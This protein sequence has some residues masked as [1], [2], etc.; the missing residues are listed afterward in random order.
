MLQKS[1]P[2]STPKHLRETFKPEDEVFYRIDDPNSKIDLEQQNS[3]TQEISFNKVI[4]AH[5]ATNRSSDRMTLKKHFSNTA[6]LLHSE[7][8]GEG[9]SKPS[10][11]LLIDGELVFVYKSGENIWLELSN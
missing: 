5:R 6:P 8:A 9:V 10:M 11:Q 7:R 2:K 3:F 4:R 1:S